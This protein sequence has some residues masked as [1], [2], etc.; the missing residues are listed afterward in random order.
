MTFGAALKAYRLD[1]KQWTLREMAKA[2][3]FPEGTLHRIEQGKVQ[4]HELTQSKIK[5]RLHDFEW[6]AQP[7]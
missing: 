7:A 2:T 4:P 5:N 6:Q 3:G 1:K